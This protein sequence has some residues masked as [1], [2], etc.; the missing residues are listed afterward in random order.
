MSFLG[1]MPGWI[2]GVIVGLVVLYQLDRIL[3]YIAGQAVRITAT[4]QQHALSISICSFLLGLLAYKL[5]WTR[6]HGWLVMEGS[7]AFLCGVALIPPLYPTLQ[8]FMGGPIPHLV[9]LMLN[10]FAGA[11]SG[12]GA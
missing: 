3:A 7:L 2:I 4:L 9:T 8:T 10:A 12:I 5:P 1:K 6:A 11:L